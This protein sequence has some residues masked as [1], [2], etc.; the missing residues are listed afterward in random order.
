MYTRNVFLPTEKSFF[1]FGPRGVGKSTLVKAK[2]PNA[3]YIDLLDSRIYQ[4]LLADP[5][6]LQDLIPNNHDQY[7]I[8]DEIQRVPELLNEVHRLIEN[9][10]VKFVLTGSSA[11]KLRRG[12]VNLLAG[13]ALT[14]HLYSLTASECGTDFDLSQAIKFGT[15]P[16]VLNLKNDEEKS[17]YLSSYI[18]TYLK[19]EV[20]A[21]GLT[22]NLAAFARFLQVASFS[23]GSTLNVSEIAREV[24]M[25]RKV[26]ENYFLILEDLM[27]GIRIPAFTKR[28]KREM[29]VKPKFYFF[30]TG[31]YQSLRPRNILDSESEVGGAALEN[32]FLQNFLA[33]TAN[34]VDKY[35]ISYFRTV[36]GSEVDF[37]V[38]GK[39]KLLAIEIK[40][41]HRYSESWLR[42][43][44][45]F[46]KDYPEAKLYLLYTGRERLYVGGI[47][48]V[49]IDEFLREMRGFVV[50]MKSK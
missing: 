30:D 28:A 4:R 48:V 32:L 31:V 5:G 25:E 7:V 33:T 49:P 29:V 44:K 21:E 47:E 34:E 42:G 26:I 43:L 22:R 14:Y 39:D 38:H 6:E 10:K 8:I 2:Y 17:R 15:L 11:R 20:V 37:V 36:S 9:M 41:S 40:S 19:E 27:L 24:M 45:Q 35:E 16:E 12:G 46:G 13:R 1:L 23:V 50:G 18:E 3:K